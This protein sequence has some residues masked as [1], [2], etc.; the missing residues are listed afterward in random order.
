MANVLVDT[1]VWVDFFRGMESPVVSSLN[2]LLEEKQVVLCGTV[3]LELLQGAKPGERPMLQDLLVALTYVETERADFQRAGE[4]LSGLRAKG[5]QV[6]ATDGLI[7]ALCFRHR[8]PILTLDKHFDH[9]HDVKK[10]K[11]APHE[12]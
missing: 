2:R 12:K 5:F 8:L 7:A 10:F 9:F 6:P 11:T 3:E 1:S 4:L